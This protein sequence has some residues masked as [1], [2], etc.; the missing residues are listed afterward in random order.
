MFAMDGAV[1]LG[2]FVLRFEGAFFPER[3]IQTSA[4][5]QKECQLAG[6]ELETSKRHHQILALAGF[7]YDAGGG[8]MVTAQYIADCLAASDSEIKNLDREMYQH[9]ATL[10]IEKNLLNETLTVSADG[11]L[12]LSDFSSSSELKAEY[13]LTDS[14][15]LSLIG[16][17][18]LE[19]PDNKKGLYGI[20]HD[21]SC[22]TLKGKISF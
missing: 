16:N 13:C 4:E 22:I 5:F 14:I 11:T 2:N 9:Q 18:Y 20:Y 7:D 12:D 8:L 17:F 21:L 6:E 15:K 3:H 1:P 10:S 19:G